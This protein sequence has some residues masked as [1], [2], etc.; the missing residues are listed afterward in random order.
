MSI[1]SQLS[2]FL[3]GLAMDAFSA[4]VEAVRTAFEGDP[5]TRRQVGFSV[6]I[7]ALSAK[8]AKDR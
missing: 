1:W 8:M 4:V 6:A 2:E 3:S 5:D 7:I